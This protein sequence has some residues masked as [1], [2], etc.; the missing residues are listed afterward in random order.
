MKWLL[1]LQNPNSIKTND[2][3]HSIIFSRWLHSIKIRSKK[4]KPR[5]Y[6]LA[7]Q[8]EEEKRIIWASLNNLNLIAEVPKRSKGANP[9]II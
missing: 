5:N 4:I 3:L 8:E 7:F 6:K 2:R 1:L 9:L